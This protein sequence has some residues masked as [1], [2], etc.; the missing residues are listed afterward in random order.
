MSKKEDLIPDF[1]SK[2]K[3][4]LVICHWSLWAPKKSGLYETVKDLVVAEN[5]L[6]GVLAGLVDPEKPE[7]GQYDPD[8]GDG[9]GIYSQNHEWAMKVANLHMVHY[10]ELA[11]SK[12]LKPKIFVTHGTVEAC[13]WSEMSEQ[14]EAGR[15]LTSSLD[16]ILNCDAT[17]TLS[18]RAHFYWKRFSQR[19]NV[20]HVHKGIDLERFTPRGM[21]VDLSGKP[22]IGYG[23]VWRGIKHPLDVLYAVA[24][25]YE[26]NKEAKF[27]PYGAGGNWRIWHKIFLLGN[28]HQMLGEHE[29]GMAIKNPEHWYRAF[30]MMIS[31]VQ[32]GEPSRAFKEALAC[33]CP[34][35][36]WNSNPFPEDNHA[37][38]KAKYC[39]P[40]DMADKI[41][42]LWSEIERCPETARLKARRIAER[43]YS[44][45]KMAEEVVKIARKVVNGEI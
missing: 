38:R 13:L 5:K 9:K 2:E 1:K 39:N 28:F 21:K 26:R 18:K 10:K 29:M 45:D 41:E 3:L 23:E 6:P 15:S 11:E 35:I 20:F 19:D 16:R 14:G 43:Y 27:H 32:Q 36:G 12:A 31:P 42:S 33:G 17:I 37:F 22:K 24:E 4:D 8:T 30:D 44:A 40:F 25:Y 34:T 7:G